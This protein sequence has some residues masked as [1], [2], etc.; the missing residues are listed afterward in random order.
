MGLLSRMLSTNDTIMALV[1]LLDSP[2]WVR[3]TPKGKLE[4]FVGNT[5]TAVD[6]ADRLKL[7]QTDAQ[8]G[9]ESQSSRKGHKTAMM[10]HH[11][12]QASPK[13]KTNTKTDPL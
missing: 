9:K 8:V 2:P 5:W 11:T 10:Q 13:S 3:R 4:K 1:P 12:H 6:P 7:T